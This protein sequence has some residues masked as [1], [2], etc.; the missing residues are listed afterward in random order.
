MA[1]WGLYG[2]PPGSSLLGFYT[3][4]SGRASWRFCCGR[5]IWVWRSPDSHNTASSSAGE[6]AI[7]ISD[8]VANI[9]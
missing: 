5:T 4:L 6:S 7:E 2:S 1:L 8:Q 3:S 9:L